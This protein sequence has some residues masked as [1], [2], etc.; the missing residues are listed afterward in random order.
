MHSK[1]TYTCRPHPYIG[2]VVA[3]ASSVGGKWLW[4]ISAASKLVHRSEDVKRHGHTQDPVRNGHRYTLHCFE[5][6]HTQTSSSLPVSMINYKASTVACH[7]S[8]FSDQ[9]A[10][11]AHARRFHV[12]ATNAEKQNS[13]SRELPTRPPRMDS[14][15]QRYTSVSVVVGLSGN[16]C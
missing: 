9:A 11:A 1:L 14:W 15:F 6:N 7:S 5:T 2:A 16:S 4:Q 13:H 3:Q 8:I 10:S 12:G